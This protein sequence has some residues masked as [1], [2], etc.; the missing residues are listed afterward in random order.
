MLL[1]AAASA[2][3]A[4]KGMEPSRPRGPGASC[5]HS[6]AWGQRPLVGMGCPSPCFHLPAWSSLANPSVK[7]PTHNLGNF[8]E[9][10][11]RHNR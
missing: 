3:S 2:R 5:S 1:S 9:D 6:L 4:G 8:L 10:P 11:D 7:A